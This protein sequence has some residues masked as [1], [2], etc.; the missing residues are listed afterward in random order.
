MKILLCISTLQ[1]GGA[2][3]NI[4]ILANLLTKKNYEVT[5]LTFDKKKVNL[6]FF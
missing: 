5:I 6:F 4:S 2:K 1:S 3:K